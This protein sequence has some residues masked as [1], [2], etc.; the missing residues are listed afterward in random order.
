MAKQFDEKRA[1]AYLQKREEKI[2]QQNEHERIVLLE[3]AIAFLKG[4]FSQGDVAV[5]LVGSIIQPF[6]FTSRSDV[7]IVLKNFQGDRFEVWTECESELHR[8]VDII[9]Y[10]SC[11]FQDY[12][13]QSG[14]RIV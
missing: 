14:L 4:K 12:I 5:Y 9:L 7:D 3:K 6:Q 10:E 13:D 11:H 2:K 8:D 1:R